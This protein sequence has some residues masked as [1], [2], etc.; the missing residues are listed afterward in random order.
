VGR[1]WLLV[2][3][4]LPRFVPLDFGL[5]AERERVDPDFALLEPFE[6]L[7]AFRVEPEFV[8]L[9]LRELLPF[10]VEP[11]REAPLPLLVVPLELFFCVRVFVWAMLPSPFGQLRDA[12]LRE[13]RELGPEPFR[14]LPDEPRDDRP[15]DPDRLDF[16]SV[17]RLTSPSSIVPRHPPSSSSAISA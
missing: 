4:A 17:F 7:A 8:L 1:C 15:L 2:R 14:L 11:F 5:L 9:E 13:P 10:R 16:R 12:A 3:E 6:R